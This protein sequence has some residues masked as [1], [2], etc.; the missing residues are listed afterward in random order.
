MIDLHSHLL[1]GVDDGSRTME[2]ALALARAA[3]AN[4]IHTSVLTPHVYPGVFDNRRSSLLPVFAEYRQALWEAGI[5]L[6]VRLGGE[7]H[8]H[9]D[10]FD[11]FARGELPMIG[12]LNGKKMMLLEFPDGA[13]PHGSDVACRMFADQGV[14]WLIAHPER[15]KAVMRNPDIIKP[16]VDM[17]CMLQLTAAS[18]VGAFGRAAGQTAH[19][20]LTRGLAH[21]VASDA[22]NL[23][24]RPPRMGEARRY[25]SQ[26]FGMGIAY[27]L[28]EENPARILAERVAEPGEELPLAQPQQA[29]QAAAPQGVIPQRMYAN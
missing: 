7:V 17:G 9:P 21:V 18:V 15:N 5:P 14:H 11:M 6:D 26:H 2:D 27:R 23:A 1:P 10:V 3:V 19:T 20:L 4:G 16:F 24:H 13:I 22:H 29:T 28:T 8:L 25:L 12:G